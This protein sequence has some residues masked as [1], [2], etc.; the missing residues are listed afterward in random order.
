MRGVILFH[1][2]RLADGDSAPE[3]TNA[4]GWPG[5]MG[6]AGFPLALALSAML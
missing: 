6:A 3:L 2:A 4:A 1:T 5:W